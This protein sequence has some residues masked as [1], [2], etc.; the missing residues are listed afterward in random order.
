ME[1]KANRRAEFKKDCFEV[2]Q[3]TSRN[4]GCGQ[5]VANP[6]QAAR[7]KGEAEAQPDM[8]PPSTKNNP[9]SCM[10]RGTNDYANG[11]LVLTH[12][13]WGLKGSYPS[14]HPNCALSVM[15]VHGSCHVIAG[16][17]RAQHPPLQQ[18]HV[19]GACGRGPSLLG[20]RS[21]RP[22]DADCAPAATQGDP[23]KE[24]GPGDKA[25]P[26]T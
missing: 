26:Q 7:Q 17:G 1:D 2:Q 9:C 25:S 6:G 3:G 5:P 18:H 20:A 16:Q 12:R 14:S 10:G 15:G 11:F 22:W 13:H 21:P 8:C 24:Q 19:H 4:S 23:G